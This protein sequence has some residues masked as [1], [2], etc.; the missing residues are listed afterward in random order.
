M[1]NN[2]IINNS[3]NSIK[4]KKNMSHSTR[5]NR[6]SKSHDEPEEKV[7][8]EFKDNVLK[9]INIDNLIK[10]KQDE[11]TDLKKKRRHHEEYI[12]KYFDNADASQVELDNVKLRKN[13]YE[14]TEGVKHDYIKEAIMEKLKDTIVTKDILE[15][16]D[17]KRKKITRVSLKRTGKRSD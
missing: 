3:V 15:N 12:L 2:D 7:S 14:T 1:D 17:N 4:S 5:A 8:D 11:L 9:Y 10:E 16:I 13:K 6:S